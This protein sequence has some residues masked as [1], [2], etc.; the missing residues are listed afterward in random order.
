MASQRH[1]ETARHQ[2]TTSAERSGGTE[3]ARRT[4]TGREREEE[5]LVAALNLFAERNFASVTIKDIAQSVNVN[6]GLIYYY[7]ENKTDLFRATIEF[8][9]EKAFANIRALEERNSDP[10]SLLS[11]WLE[12]HV[13]KYAEIHRFVK[14]ALDFRGSQEGD[15]AIEATIAN[16]Y[17]KEGE[18]L[19]R[20]IRQGIDRGLFQPVDSTRMGQFISTYLD[21]CM[22]RS[23]ILPN[24]NLKVA[25]GDLHRHMFELLT[26]NAKPKSKNKGKPRLRRRH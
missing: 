24:F 13:E 21:G 8:A 5:F 1:K 10:A 22:V 17:A 16:F 26:L 6:T 20:F 11:A 25:V 19:S 14:I 23:V 12:N 9:V 2:F 7:F 4:D 15:A 18:L 3:P